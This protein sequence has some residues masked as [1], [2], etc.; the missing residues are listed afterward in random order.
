LIITFPRQIATLDQSALVQFLPYLAKMA[1]G[2]PTQS[3]ECQRQIRL[4]V[5]VVGV[6]HPDVGM[7]E[8]NWLRRL[9]ANYR[10]I[11]DKR[12]RPMVTFDRKPLAAS[13]YGDKIN[14]NLPIPL[15]NSASQ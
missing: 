2:R 10:F 15:L 14:G 7:I 3:E 5:R 8:R 13:E 11:R 1:E 12:T 9:R 6:D 4:A